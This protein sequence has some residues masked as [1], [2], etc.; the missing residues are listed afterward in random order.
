[1]LLISLFL[2]LLLKTLDVGLTISFLYLLESQYPQ[3]CLDP[4]V[5]HCDIGFLGSNFFITIIYTC[6]NLPFMIV[7]YFMI[8]KYN[9]IKSRVRYIIFFYFLHISIVYYTCPTSVMEFHLHLRR[10]FQTFLSLDSFE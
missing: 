10:E 6:Y 9:D 2:W 1:M 5:D 8:I 4:K 7:L 3:S